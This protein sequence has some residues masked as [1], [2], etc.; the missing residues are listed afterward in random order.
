[1]PTPL[2]NIRVADELW[3]AAKARAEAEGTTVT[4]VIVAALQRYV[5]RR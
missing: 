3:Q 2:R 1:M 5:R 4:E